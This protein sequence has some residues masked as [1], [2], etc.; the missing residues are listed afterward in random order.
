L[1]LLFFFPP[2]DISL[3]FRGKMISLVSPPRSEPT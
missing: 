3:L 2:P 1:L